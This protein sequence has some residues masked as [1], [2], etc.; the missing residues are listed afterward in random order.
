MKVLNS[1]TYS[2]WDVSEFG[3]IVRTGSC[4]IQLHG[5]IVSTMSR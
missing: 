3:V 5:V 2:W 4:G 1:V